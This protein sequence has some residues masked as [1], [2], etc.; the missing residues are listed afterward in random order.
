MLNAL[1]VG[2]LPDGRSPEG[3]LDLLGNVAEWTC[4]MSLGQV[5]PDRWRHEPGTHIVLG[6]S[7]QDSG[8][9][10]GC[11]NLV[12]SHG[13]GFITGIRLGRTAPEELPHH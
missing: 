12:V 13:G 8:K 3:V 7:Y 1:P 11:D 5:A 6:L 9:Y 10:I 4:S 2:S